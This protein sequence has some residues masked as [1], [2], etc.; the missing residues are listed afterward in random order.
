MKTNY[1]LVLG[2]R[3]DASAEEIKSA[4]RRLALE[5]HPDRSGLES[6]PFRRVQEA[7]NV[8]SDPVERQRYDKQ[9]LIR[10]KHSS[11]A[12]PLV[13][14]AEERAF[15]E[16][17]WID[18]VSLF[19]S[20]ER[21]GPSF[22]ELFDRLWSNFYP[23]NRPKAERPES[24]T[25][26]IPLTRQQALRGGRVRIL[27]PSITQCPGCAGRGHVGGFEC[28]RCAGN[29]SVEVAMPVVVEFPPSH[30]DS[31]VHA[32]LSGTGIENLYLTVRFRVR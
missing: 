17:P 15:G 30:L 5:L 29:G 32:S 18:E 12:E 10:P 22:E 9:I 8:L 2:V 31:V 6:E 21:F 23:V 7:Y 14:R 13:P 16:E 27:V 11:G 28:W 19:E 25:L 24:L 3:T 20:F 26:D 4:F 1:Y